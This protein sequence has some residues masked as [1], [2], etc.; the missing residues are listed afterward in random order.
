MPE[1]PIQLYTLKG[2]GGTEVVHACSLDAALS[3]VRNRYRADGRLIGRVV[4]VPN[5]ASTGVLIRPPVTSECQAIRT[6]EWKRIAD[7]TLVLAR[8]LYLERA[9]AMG[10][11]L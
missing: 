9:A 10:I 3:T 7:A 6:R 5:G 11:K 4:H 8:A 1:T 2:E